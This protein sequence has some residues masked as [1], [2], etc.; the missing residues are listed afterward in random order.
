VIIAMIH[1]YILVSPLPRQIENLKNMDFSHMEI[2]F[3]IKK[4]VEDMGLC[5]MQVHFCLW[6]FINEQRQIS[7]STFCM[8]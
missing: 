3:A 4:M 5:F 8:L 2:K 1:P 6:K 7:K